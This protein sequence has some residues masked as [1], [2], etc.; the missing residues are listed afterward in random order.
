MII[1]Q[2]YA[3]LPPVLYAKAT[4]MPVA[5]PKLV[6]ANDALAGELGLPR[7]W[8]H[9]EA[10]LQMLSGNAAAPHAEPLAMAY[11]GHQFGE[12]GRAHV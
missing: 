5:A 9:S 3:A 10:T 8:L 1:E 11:A 2:S 7:E 12:I 4:L 6:M